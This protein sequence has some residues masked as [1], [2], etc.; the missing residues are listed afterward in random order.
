MKLGMALWLLWPMEHV[1]LLV[2]DSLP[3]SPHS[4][5]SVMCR[6]HPGEML[7]GGRERCSFVVSATH[8]WGLWIREACVLACPAPHMWNFAER[9]RS[10]PAVVDVGVVSVFYMEIAKCRWGRVPLWNPLNS[11]L[12]PSV[13]LAFETKAA[14]GS[15]VGVTTQ[16]RHSSPSWFNQV[17]YENVQTHQRV[18]L[19]SFPTCYLLLFLPFL[20]LETAA[21]FYHMVQIFLSKT[22]YSG[23]A[24]TKSLV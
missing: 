11:S 20:F 13:W 14:F 24:L 15:C 4:E 1:Y 7:T 3:L 19:V 9:G 6:R 10:F 18:L 21:H 23:E 12:S 5:V 22:C 16:G 8:V 2:P 17:L